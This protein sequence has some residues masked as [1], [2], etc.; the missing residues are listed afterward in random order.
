MLASTATNAAS[1]LAANSAPSCVDF[2]A[3][4]AA[5]TAACAS[6]RIATRIE[7]ISRVATAA[8]PA[9]LRTSSATT[10]KPRPFS[11]ARAASIAA[12]SA[13]RFVWS[14]MPSIVATISPISAVRFSSVLS[15]LSP[16]SDARCS[17]PIISFEAVAARRPV[18]T[19]TRASPV[20]AARSVPACAS[21]CTSLSGVC[22]SPTIARNADD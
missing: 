4:R 6:E 8:L 7:P 18:S 5:V 14:A 3:A 12:L 20:A 19:W 9:S 15:N 2:D 17:R 22:T 1:A 13:S 16:S 10:A 21:P 11:P